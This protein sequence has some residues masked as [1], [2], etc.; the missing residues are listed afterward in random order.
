MQ[1]IRAGDCLVRLF[2]DCL[3]RLAR[4]FGKSVWQDCLARLFGKIVWQDSTAQNL[5]CVQPPAN[6]FGVRVEPLHGWT[7]PDETV[8]G[9]G[10][11]TTGRLDKSGGSLRTIRAKLS[12]VFRVRAIQFAAPR[13]HACKHGEPVFLG[14][15]TFRR[16]DH[17]RA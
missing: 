11:A 7:D 8:S 12:L 16:V 17:R 9:K 13:Q 5:R 10:D 3:A 2:G 6:W 1:R 4:L 15:G 14:F